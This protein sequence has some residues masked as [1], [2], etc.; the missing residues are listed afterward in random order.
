M[1]AAQ[2]RDHVCNCLQA[3]EC[4]VLEFGS[5]EKSS[6]GCSVTGCFVWCGS[7]LPCAF[8]AV[9]SGNYL[10]GAELWESTGNL[11][12]HHGNWGRHLDYAHPGPGFS[13]ALTFLVTLSIFSFFKTHL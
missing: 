10:K 6:S 3:L 4:S 7:S 11:Q 8:S 1:D 13:F 12:V 9:S 5:L 2:Q